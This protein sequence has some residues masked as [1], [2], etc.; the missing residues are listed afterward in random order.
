MRAW[1][2]N[3]AD[4]R[5]VAAAGQP[6]QSFHN[7]HSSETVKPRSWLIKKQDIWVCNELYS[8]RSSLT[9][10]SRNN[11]PLYGSDHA[12]LTLAEAELFDKLLNPS[13]LFS[14]AASQF[15]SR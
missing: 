6:L 10:S 1:L 12:V 8:Y 4:D 2:V 15:K 3:G 11:L 5:F 14:L 13:I 9:L 7:S